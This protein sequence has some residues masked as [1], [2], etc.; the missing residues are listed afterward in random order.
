METDGAADEAP[1]F[2]KT[3]STAVD[4]FKDLKLDVLLHGVNASGLLAFNPV[5]RRMA[6]LSHDLE[7]IIL[8]HD[9]FR[10]RLDSARKMKD[11]DLE[12]KNF[13][14]AAEILSEIWSK[15]VI[16]GHPV[17]C[18]VIPLGQ[19]HVPS[20]PD[21]TWVSKHVQQPWYSLQIL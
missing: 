6:P 2:L 12:K 10:N 4:L 7:G 13:F 9:S 14:Q 17:D 5:E 18:L 1:R 16:D 15:M 11:L 8:P 19:E 20:T 3:L 21:P